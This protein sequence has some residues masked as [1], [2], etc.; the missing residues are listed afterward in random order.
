MLTA[1]LNELTK[2]FRRDELLAAI[3]K[4]GVPAGPINTI[5]HVFEDP[6]V[7]ARGMKMDVPNARAAGGTTPGLRAPIVMDG[8]AMA[9]P[10]PAPA[11]GEHTA[12]VLGDPSW[13]G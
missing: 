13:G 8:A 10:L 4:V 1:R 12:E 2:R 9:A 7:I 5:R 6:Q 11:L 3:E